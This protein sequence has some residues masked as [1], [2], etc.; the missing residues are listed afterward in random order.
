MEKETW[1]VPRSVGGRV[2]YALVTTVLPAACFLLADA[3]KPEWQSGRLADYAAL[4][5]GPSVTLFFAPFLAYAVV[6]LILL[7]IAPR[8]FARLFVVRLGIYGGFFLALQYAVLLGIVFSEG[9][10]VLPILGGIALCALPPAAAWLY[11]LAGRKLGAVVVRWAVL[12]AAGLGAV[13]I[14]A[15]SALSHGAPITLLLVLLLAGAPFWCLDIAAIV[16]YRL[17]TGYELQ[18]WRAAWRIGGAAAWL[19]AFGAAWRFAMARMW[20]EYAALPLYPLECYVATAA[21]NGHPGFVRSWPV[22]DSAGRPF[23]VNRQLLRL[24]CA[25]LALRAAWPAGHRRL[26][27]AY[28]AVGPRLARRL[29]RPLLADAAYLFLK[30][31]EWGSWAVLRALWPEAAEMAGRLYGA[32]PG[33]SRFVPT[34][35][36]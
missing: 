21:A 28:D 9:K 4:L 19:A 22:V 3:L 18:G 6:C 34:S 15:A 16:S 12:V 2:L 8:R 14:G 11:N 17:L 5:L 30:P 29:R 13:L 32:S 31:A 1:P 26:R 33:T 23:R 27:R 36:S 35:K 7:L 25:E 24:K 10:P 20:E